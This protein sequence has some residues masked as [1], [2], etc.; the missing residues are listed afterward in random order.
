MNPNTLDQE[1]TQGGPTT[2]PVITINPDGSQSIGGDDGETALLV[3]GVESEENLSP[4]MRLLRE[5]RGEQ[6]KTTPARA[7]KIR[8]RTFYI[9]KLNYADLTKLGMLSDR[10]EDG[11][12]D[13]LSESTGAQFMS[14]VMFVSLKQAADGIDPLFE[15]FTEAWQFANDDADEIIEA[16]GILFHAILNV[17]PQVLPAARRE[18][19]NWEGEGIKK[20]E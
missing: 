19:I 3:P 17:N 20:K 16:V 8:D 9:K 18:E 7:L 10:L 14:A 12:L 4:A 5:M 2:A 11:T 15:T 1:E 13:I 6:K